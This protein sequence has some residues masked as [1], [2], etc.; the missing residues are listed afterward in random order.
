MKWMKSA[1]ALLMALLLLPTAASAQSLYKATDPEDRADLNVRLVSPQEKTRLSKMP[2]LTVAGSL[3]APELITIDPQEPRMPEIAVAAPVRSVVIPDPSPKETPERAVVIPDPSPREKTPEETPEETPEKAPAAPAPEPKPEDTAAAAGAPASKT[4]SFPEAEDWQILLVNPWN[5]MPEDYEVTLKALSDGMK[6]DERAYDDLN[7]ML[8]ACRDAGLRPKI[9]SAYR[10]MSKQTYLYNNKISRL[11]NAGYG[12]AAA[13][14][15]AGRWV[16]RP[17]TSEHQLGLA[18]DI[19]SSSYQSLTK[20]Q[21]QTKEQKWLMEHCWEYG[22]ILRYPNSKSEI[23]GIGYE[24]WHYRYV[25]REVALDIRD[26]GLCME[27][28]I[29]LREKTLAE[30]HM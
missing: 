15:E 16:A 21:E 1:A 9:C 7:A 20:K 6:V 10:T 28:Y 25:G 12:K 23:T 13:R 11:M 26:S 22:F 24:P 14:K 18:V 2:E 3:A 27:E 17:G 5:E 29:A 19:V 4:P 8:Q 30:N